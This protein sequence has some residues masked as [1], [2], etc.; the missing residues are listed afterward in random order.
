MSIAQGSSII[1]TDVQCNVG[2][3]IIIYFNRSCLYTYIFFS[4]LQH[5]TCS[6]IVNGVTFTNAM[7]VNQCQNAQIAKAVFLFSVFILSLNLLQDKTIFDNKS[8]CSGN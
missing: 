2:V 7:Y 8:T 3:A 1:V 5:V 4:L 6:K